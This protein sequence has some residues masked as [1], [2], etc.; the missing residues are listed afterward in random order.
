MRGGM[1]LIEWQRKTKPNLR[2]CCISTFET[3]STTIGIDSIEPKQILIQKRTDCIEQ[4][5]R[6]EYNLFYF[7]ILILIL[8]FYAGLIIDPPLPI[9]LDGKGPLA[10]GS[11]LHVHIL[12]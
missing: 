10:S 5:F 2:R 8:F 11:M 3:N 9:G 7:I 1:F 4:E 12:N 6:L